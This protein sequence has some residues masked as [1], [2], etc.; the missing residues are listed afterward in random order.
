M[1]LA[2]ASDNAHVPLIAQLLDVRLDGPFAESGPSAEALNRGIAAPFI[3]RMISEREHDQ[4][5]GWREGCAFENSRHQ[6][7]THAATLPTN[8]VGPL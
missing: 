1:T 8:S 5:L 7:N 6:T 4:P 3:V 2:T